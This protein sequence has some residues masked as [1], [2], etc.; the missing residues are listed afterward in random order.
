MMTLYLPSP[1]LLPRAHAVGIGK[2]LVGLCFW[3]LSSGSAV[4]DTPSPLKVQLLWYHQSQFAG[5][6]VA[7][8]RKHFEAEGLEVEFLEGGAGI[9]PLAVLQRG[10]ADI[11]LSWFSN[12]WQRSPAEPAVTNVAQIFSGSALAVVCRISAG[13]YTANDI[14]GKQIGI[15]EL[16]DEHVVQEMLRLLSIPLADVEL[17]MQ[18][19]NGADLISGKLP[20]VTAMNYN[21]YWK[22]LDA[23]IPATDLLIV[24]P[25]IFGIAHV[26]DG[27]Y[28]LTERL[29]S[30]EFREE[31]ARFLRALRRGWQEARIAPTLAIE[32]VQRIAPDLNREHQRHML[33]TVL[34]ITM[35]DEDFGR[36]DLAR[37]ES[38]KRTLLTH[39]DTVG[40]PQLI[41][42]HAISNQLLEM[43]GKNS[44]LTY[45]TRHHVQSIMAHPAFNFFLLF[46]VLVYA[47]SGLLEAVNRGYDIWGRLI[48]AVM[49]GLGGTTLREFLIGGDRLPLYYVANL[50]Y[51]L[52]ILALVIVVSVITFM[53][54]NMHKSATFKSVKNYADIVGFSIMAMTGAMV[55]IVANLHWIWV[56]ICAA[57]TCAGGG[58]LR[59]IVINREPATLKGVI[60]E[61]VAV[62][63]SFVM[64]AGLVIANLFENSAMPVYLSLAA[65]ILS[66]IALR[67]A[68]YKLHWRYP[69]FAKAT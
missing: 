33:E 63:G 40:E 48:L 20:C 44:A 66:I 32:T 16:G 22:I 51:P 24:S 30:P 52:S 36:L 9:N 23:G 69:G 11:A 21:E 39:G 49:S 8:A 62:L 1:V 68:I 37:Y 7:Q 6:Y 3:L 61:E 19:P 31:L 46:G 58:M 65:S 67:L 18:A 27:L 41:W 60:Y 17:V 54:K 47:L 12:A 14:I 26:E 34:S 38:A 56:P 2:V 5:L 53:F 10:E 15:W 42:T 64:I 43:D 50:V 28:V 13:V 55:A 29:E 45:A 25:E 59:D 57:L 35:D 4:A